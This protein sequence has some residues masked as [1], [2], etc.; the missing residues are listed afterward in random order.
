MLNFQAVLTNVKFDI[1]CRNVLYFEN[2]EAQENYFSVASLFSSAQSINFNAG[3]LIETTIIYQ[4]QENESINDILSKNYCIIKDNNENATLKY[5]YYYVKNIIQDSGNQVKVWLELDIFQTYF[6]DIKFSDCEILRA[7]LNR[8]EKLS[9]NGVTSNQYITFADGTDS[10]LFEREPIQNLSKRLTKR[11]KLSTNTYFKNNINERDDIINNWLDENIVCWVYAYFDRTHEYK[12]SKFNEEGNV[13]RPFSALKI[14]TKIVPFATK[15]ES[16]GTSPIDIQFRVVAVPILKGAKQLYLKGTNGNISRLNI[17][18]LNAFMTENNDSAYLAT[19]K[20]S[21]IPPFSRY[22]YGDESFENHN[23]EID[24]SGNLTIEAKST[25]TNGECYFAFANGDVFNIRYNG[26]TGSTNRGIFVIDTQMP[27]VETIYYRSN[28]NDWVAFNEDKIGF[29]KSEIINSNK[30]SKYNPKL[31]SADYKSLKVCNQNGQGFIYD[32]Q[33]LNKNRFSLIVSEPFLPNISK[34]YI[35]IKQLDGIYSKETTENM[36]GAVI[37]FDS[38]LTLYSDRY[39]EML[40][41]QKN[42][43]MQNILGLSSQTLKGIQGSTTV[44]D[45]AINSSKSLF[46]AGTSLV[47]TGLTIDNMEQAPDSYKIGSQEIILS[48]MASNIGIYIEEYECIE[49]EKEIVNDQMCMNGYVYNQIGNIKDFVNIRKYY[50][51]IQANIQET[52]GI[53]ISKTVHERFKEM[54]LRGVRFWNTDTF[55]YKLENYEKWLEE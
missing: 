24:S 17:E 29:T 36:T 23:Y 51:F 16:S 8:F 4:V 15:D 26:E 49:N 14:G 42:F 45:L 53:N 40:A 35:R 54:F 20:I 31:L 10:K 6:I 2:R 47:N 7:H 38:S 30:N 13:L 41:N 43:H 33:K 18:S 22:L 55:S 1:D 44:K 50:N 21:S 48:L 11:T 37:E 27:I 52:S 34:S 25:S 5:Y 3:S 12:F 28:D 32:I 46:N 9:N 39:K 19:I